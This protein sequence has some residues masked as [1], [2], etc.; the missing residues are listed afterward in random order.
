MFKVLDTVPGTQQAVLS[1]KHVCC[2]LCIS[3]CNSLFLYIY[4]YIYLFYLFT[5]GCFGSLLLCAAFP[6]CSEG[7]SLFVAVCGLLT[8][9]ASLV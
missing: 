7:G 6:S 9:V 5:F 3:T 4:I 8:A 2:S 1:H